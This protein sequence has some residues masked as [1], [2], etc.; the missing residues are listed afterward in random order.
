MRRLSG[1]KKLTEPYV[2]VLHL[3]K[4]T[5]TLDQKTIRLVLSDFTVVCI[6]IRFR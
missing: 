4:Y 5:S 2:D 1:I 6:K 3:N